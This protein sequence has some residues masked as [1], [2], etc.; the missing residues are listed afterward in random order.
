[1]VDIGYSWQ[2]NNVNG[3]FQGHEQGGQIEIIK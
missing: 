3:N 1:M 2:I